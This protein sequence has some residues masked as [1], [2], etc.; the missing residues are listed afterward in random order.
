MSASA[1]AATEPDQGRL[2]VRAK[3]EN[4]GTRFDKGKICVYTR[5]MKNET[6][7]LDALA[8]AEV[9][10]TCLCLN[11]RKMARVL[12][13]HYDAYLQTDDLRSTQFSLLVAIALAREVPLTRLAEA[14]AMNRT[15]LT[16]NLKPLERQHLITVETSSQD[17]R[18]RVITL[19]PQGY[20]KVKDALPHWKQAQS[21]LMALLGSQQS[22][23]LLIDAQTVMERVPFSA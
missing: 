15:T 3:D 4:V 16:R 9:E 20:Q 22:Q 19:T 17:R 2:S 1:A 11:V 18:V 12:T 21:Q 5:N 23:A 14:V 10:T 7:P 13:H 6:P 8:L